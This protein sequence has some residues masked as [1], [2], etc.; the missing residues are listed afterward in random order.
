MG[1]PIRTS[2]GHS[3]FPTHRGFSQVIA[4]FFGYQCQGI[5]L[6][7]FFAWT[8]VFCFFSIQKTCFY[9]LSFANNCFGLWTKRPFW[10][11][12]HRFVRLI[13]IS[14]YET[15]EIVFL[16]FDIRKNLTNFLITSFSQYTTICFVSFSLFGFQW[17]LTFFEKKAKQRNFSERLGYDPDRKHTLATSY[18]RFFSCPSLFKEGIYNNESCLGS[19]PLGN[20]PSSL[21]TITYNLRNTLCFAGRPKWTRTT[22][23]VL[24]RHAL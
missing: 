8:A 21:F 11:F 16:P 22:D 23:L 24:I 14:P 13:W 7:L 1:F 6:T 5:H 4:S 15:D 17:T 12:I 19:F 20:I 18:F 3:L 2:A 10:F 9:C